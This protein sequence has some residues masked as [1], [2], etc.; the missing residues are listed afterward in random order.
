MTS[1]LGLEYASSDEE[2]SHNT[3]D[4]T[5]PKVNLA[6]D[7]ADACTALTH[8][9][10]NSGIARPVQGP[11]LPHSTGGTLKRKMALTGDAVETAI[12]DSTFT[13]NQRTYESLGY[14]RDPTVHGAF[15]GDLAKAQA[16]GGKD[17]VQTRPSR[18]QSLA[19]KR[20]RQKRG[21]A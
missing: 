4:S 15:V 5:V 19:F 17:I 1:L 10:P 20:R 2:V 14:A 12:S 16:Y 11:S 7:V 3:V 6:P 18:E 13:T 8:N 21:D 9:V